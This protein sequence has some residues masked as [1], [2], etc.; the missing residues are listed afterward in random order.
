M[1]AEAESGGWLP[2][3]I[4]SLGQAVNGLGQVTAAFVTLLCWQRS[5]EFAVLKFL[6]LSHICCFLHFI[7][8][9]PFLPVLYFFPF[10]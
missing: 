10:V 5:A 2:R 4:L 9:L 6:F 7:L 8:F 1:A 3:G